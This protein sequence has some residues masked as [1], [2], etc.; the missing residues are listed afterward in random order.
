MHLEGIAILHFECVGCICG[1]DALTVEEEA[2]GLDILALTLAEGRHKFLELCGSLD[3]KEDLIVVVCDL[4]VEVLGGRS[5][6]LVA[7][8][9]TVV[10]HFRGGAG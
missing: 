9:S 10:G 7:L 6:A 5:S 3:L 2:H 1:L 8:R 4:D